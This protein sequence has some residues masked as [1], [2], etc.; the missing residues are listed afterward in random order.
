MGGAA[1]ALAIAVTVVGIRLDLGQL[2]AVIHHR[3]LLHG[4]VGDVPLIVVG[5]GANRLVLLRR[6][7]GG[8]FLRFH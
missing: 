3:M 1:G 8:I 5:D 7:A 2:V 6:S 4:I